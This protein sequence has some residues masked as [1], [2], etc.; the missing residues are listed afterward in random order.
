MTETT[1]AAPALLADLAGSW[2]THL[3]AER[4][5][6][7]TIRVYS[8][9][10]AGFI[11]WHEANAAPGMPVTLASLDRKTAAAYLAD[12]LAGGAAP[13]T[14]R[15]RH[16]A[17]RRFSA[18]LA[19]DGETDT[20]VLIMLKPP[21][22]DAPGVDSISGAELAALLKACRAPAAAGRWTMFECLRDEAVIR[23][24][25]DTGARAGELIAL[26][27]D[28]VDLRA[29][30]ATITRAKGGKRRIA[31]F[32]AETAR[33]ID[34][35]LRKARRGH[36]QA[37]GPRLWLG[38]SNRGWTYPA[39]QGALYKR[40]ETAGIKGMHAHRLRHTSASAMLDAGVAEGDVLAHHGWSNRAMLDR[41]VHDTA[42]RRAAD[43]VKRYFDGQDR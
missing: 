31:A 43:N 18:W 23:L 35:Y 15:A 21:K 10:V 8:A 1:T 24:L 14:A 29:R 32:S 9:G 34:R 40:A 19:E 28:D 39:L 41:Y 30:I 16:A 36:K 17:L 7:G 3:A 11:G 6:P 38:T 26:R 42:Q 2:V 37:G 25:A 12:V 33:A 5:A 22:Q 4:K 20:D 13:A 27:V